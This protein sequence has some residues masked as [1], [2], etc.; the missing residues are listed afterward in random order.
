M[1][2]ELQKD[3]PYVVLLPLIDSNTFRATLRPSRHGRD[4][5][6]DL[7]LRIESA[8]DH[9]KAAAWKH[10]LYIA[11]GWNPFELVDSAVA[12]AAGKGLCIHGPGY[13]MSAS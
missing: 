10:A 9:V 1:L 3:G 2:L 5:E 4:H 11:A 6:D 12:T 7:R 13:D 8:A